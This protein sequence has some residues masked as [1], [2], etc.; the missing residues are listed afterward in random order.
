MDTRALKRF[1]AKVRK[2]LQTGCWIWIAGKNQDGYGSF[3]L[4]GPQK[5]HRVSYE[6]FVNPIPADT[7]IDHLCGNRLCVNPQHLEAVTHLT[8]LWRSPTW[9]G[10]RTHCPKGHE[11]TPENIFP[12]DQKRG[13]RRCA[14]CHRI[15][16]RARREKTRQ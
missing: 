1:Q 15:D 11:L 10:N 14:Q 2:N 3:W 9:M 6:H 7:E 16:Q 4:N 8:N 13:V 5:A 12:C